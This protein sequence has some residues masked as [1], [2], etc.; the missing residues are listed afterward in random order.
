MCKAHATTFRILTVCLVPPERWSA[1]AL[2]MD[3]FSATQRTFIFRGA[4]VVLKGGAPA[5]L[6][7]SGKHIKGR[8]QVEGGL[9][10]RL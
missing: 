1:T 3:G 7:L 9:R 5:G 4:H 6:C 8:D 10:S 2:E